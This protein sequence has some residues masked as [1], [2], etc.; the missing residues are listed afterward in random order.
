MR[1]PGDRY[2]IAG[3]HRG[4]PVRDTDEDCS[5]AEFPYG[6]CTDLVEGSWIIDR[7][8]TK[9]EHNWRIAVRQEVLK[10]WR[11]RPGRIAQE[12]KT[13]H[14]SRWGPIN[15]RLAKNAW[16]YSQREQW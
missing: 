2:D 1:R 14:S 3:A 13:G 16:E 6:I 11:E 10:L 9:R 8:R 7:R 5:Q 12:W 15:L 4:I